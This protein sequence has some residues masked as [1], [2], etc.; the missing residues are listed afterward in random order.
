MKKQLLTLLAVLLTCTTAIALTTLPG[1]LASNTVHLSVTIDPEGA[2]TVDRPERDIVTGGN[3]T[4][5]AVA[6]AGYSFDGWYVNGALV[7]HD[8]PYQFKNNMT[9]LNIVA[10]FNTL[11]ASTLT[12]SPKPGCEPMGSVDVTPEGTVDG[13]N[14]KLNTGT[15]VTVSATPNTG[16]EFVQWEDGAGNVLSTSTSYSFTVNNDGTFS[17]DGYFTLSA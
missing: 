2:G 6:N 8:N 13:Y 10:K 11:A 5:T 12:L 16:Y 3:A 7:S 17:V 4:F 14:H 15:K 1:M 9:D